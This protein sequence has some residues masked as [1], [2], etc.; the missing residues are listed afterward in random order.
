MMMDII[1]ENSKEYAVI[2]AGEDKKDFTERMILENNI[3]W[4]VP[5]SVREY[6]GERSY[7][8]DTTSRR[9]FSEMFQNENDH[10]GK[11]DVEAVCESMT[12]VSQSVREYLLDID[13]I[14]LSPESFVYNTETGCFEFI[15][16]PGRKENEDYKGDFRSG[17]RAVWEQVLKKINRDSDR[18][19]IMKLYDMYQ[20][21]SEDNFNP[22]SV[23]DIREEKEKQEEIV[24]EF[25]EPV[26]SHEVKPEAL[27]DDEKIEKII[28]EEEKKA[29][30]KKKKY[31]MYGGLAAAAIAG[32][33]V[34]V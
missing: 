9:Y 30:D 4:L 22:E 33:A 10:M 19:F 11:R 23:F 3:P 27:C 5:V 26:R 24:T 2:N 12:G 21:M 28:E 32:I 7:Y 6:N 29:P 8:Y 16:I 25:K 20:K 18:E 31:F 17:V 1:K 34:M 13:D 15:Y 14:E